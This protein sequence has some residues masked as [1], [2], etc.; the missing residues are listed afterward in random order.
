MYTFRFIKINLQHEMDPLHFKA[1][2]KEC[3]P[4]QCHLGRNKN[5]SLLNN[6]AYEDSIMF[7][8]AMVSLN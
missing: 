8:P 2:G 6:L 3:D 4:V 1:N 5:S 7:S